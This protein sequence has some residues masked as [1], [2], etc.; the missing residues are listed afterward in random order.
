[1][2]S[3]QLALYI[4]KRLTQ[5]KLAKEH[6]GTWIALNHCFALQINNYYHD[7]YFSASDYGMNWEFLWSSS[8]YL[9]TKPFK[10][11]ESAFHAQCEWDI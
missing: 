10:Y 11:S 1:M 8:R 9:K 4:R 7:I 5:F 2:N 3:K 6:F